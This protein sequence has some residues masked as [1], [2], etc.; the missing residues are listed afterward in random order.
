[1]NALLLPMGTDRPRL[2]GVP[3]EAIRAADILFMV[4]W[5]GVL[6]GVAEVLVLGVIKFGSL[7]SAPAGWVSSYFK[8]RHGYLWLSPHVVWMA[9]V[10][11]VAILTVPALLLVAL[12]RFKVTAI[13][14]RVAAGALAFICF[15]SVLM[16]YQRLYDI[17][18][19]LLAGGLAVQVAR[20]V[21][22]HLSGF[23]RLVRRTGKWLAAGVV[24]VAVGMNAAEVLRE[25]IRLAGL[26]AA[27]S[28][29]A[30]VLLLILDT[31][32]AFNLSVH[33]YSRQTTPNLEQLGARGVVFD[34]AMATSPWTLPSQ[35]SLFTG[36]LPYEFSA[37]FLTPYEGEYTTLAERLSAHGYM[38]AGF[39][40][41]LAYLGYESGVDRGFLHYEDYRI[42]PSEFLLS[43]ALGRR[44]AFSRVL[45]RLIAYYDVLNE[46]DAADVTSD[47]VR[48]VKR[49]PRERPFF[50][51]LNYMDTH[52]PYLPP[53]RYEER[54]GSPNL[55]RNYLNT[56]YPRWATRADRDQLSPEEVRAELGAYDGAIAYIDDQIGIL[57]DD[58]R[59]QGI[60]HNTLVIVASDHGE[61]FG[62][63]DLHL[64]GNSLY[65]PVLHVPM[66]LVFE[67]RVPVGKRIS[68]PASIRDVPATVMSLLGFT[69]DE[70]FPGA[71]LERYWSDTGAS[72]EP[73]TTPIFS[74]L[75]D[76]RGAPTTKSILVGRY[77][78]IWGENRFEV[79]FDTESDPD[80]LD[81]LM[82]PDNLT[83]V[84]QM[85]RALAPHIRNDRALWSR[86][87]AQD[88][89]APRRA[90]RPDARE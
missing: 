64:H 31:V 40:A 30:N 24:V 74:E 15:V 60:L 22:A 77:H 83:L 32:R 27:P 54:F 47:F 85:R 25:R 10:T 34:R 36:R 82:H 6:V 20:L 62:E 38:T 12:N 89:D 78:Y 9:P 79:L 90:P 59:E 41:N 33:E 8:L 37:N 44:L 80:E 53:P 23:R 88:E 1:M 87:P 19:I 26:P 17:A 18:I 58:L 55:R 84:T 81:N 45:R 13:S 43:T 21:G 51:F 5:F 56:Y 11:S 39:V 29:A 73:L 46:K 48:W 66:M 35:V 61:Q 67:D 49:R 65:M 70:T 71:S 42:T 68:T 16:V 52:E 75:T 50:A 86:L 57:L 63:H 3:P 4:L 72:D 14:V 76:I 69:R 2:P 28:G 7:A